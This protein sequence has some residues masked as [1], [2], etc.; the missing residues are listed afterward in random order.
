ML[1]SPGVLLP[2]FLAVTIV[3]AQIETL[4]APVVNPHSFELLANSR[5]SVHSGFTSS[6]PNQVLANVLWAMGKAP[7]LGSFQEIYVAT[8]SNV[9]LYSPESHTMSVHLSGN[10]RYSPNS[11]FEIGV[12]CERDE[13][14]G[15]AIQ[16]GLLAATAFW[17]SAS[18][19]VAS[20]PM[21]F[22]T[23]YANSNWRPNHPI[24]MVNV[25]GRRN[26]PG[27]V[28]TV[29]AVSSDS[30][31]PLPRVTGPDTFELLLAGLHQDSL[32]GQGNL[33]LEEVSQLLWAGFG[34]A[35][36]MTSNGRRGTTIPSAIA[37]YYLT[38]RIYLVREVGVHRYHNRL[39]PGTGLTTSD[40]RIE[41]VTAG[42][43]RDQ[44]RA[45]CPRLPRSA[46]VY[47]VITVGDTTSNYN[48]LEA[49]FAAFQYLMQANQ[50]GLEGF[51]TAPLTPSER[52]AIISALGIPSSD[53]PLIVFSVGQSLTGINQSTTP[54]I[55]PSRLTAI[56]SRP[57]VTIEYHTG[58]ELPARLTIIDL[59][60]RTVR[61]FPIKHG[62]SG[63]DCLVWDGL[64]NSGTPVPAGVYLVRLELTGSTPP[65]LTHMTIAR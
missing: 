22:A 56:G 32:F 3:R 6:L 19:S 49:A 43:R 48:R 38:R 4:P 27:L 65:L 51:L 39:P 45:A 5:Y 17:D 53:F 13:E 30:S 42:D 11:A 58:T 29:Q 33:S 40:H 23:N 59:V 18:G 8:P 41:L 37:N 54:P 16:A 60:G 31:L 2:G 12:A 25:H 52:T 28:R 26:G 34:V 20:C 7:A 64:N 1:K 14:A 36:H 47:V 35:P 55:R 46:P 50:L 21:Q 44:L 63:Q 15:M 10:H 57:P 9:Y 24:R 61:T 62:E